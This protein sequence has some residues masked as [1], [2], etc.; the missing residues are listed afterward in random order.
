MR[1]LSLSYFYLSLSFLFF[2]SLSSLFSLSPIAQSLSSV[3]HLCQGE[4][5][6][7]LSRAALS[8]STSA[9][10]S[11][12]RLIFALQSCLR[13]TLLP[14]PSPSLLH[15]A[16]HSALSLLSFATGLQRS[17]LFFSLPP[18]LIT[19]SSS[20]F[21]LIPTNPLSPSFFLP[22][23]FYSLFSPLSFSTL[24]LI[25]FLSLFPFFSLSSFYLSSHLHLFF[26]IFLSFIFSLISPSFYLLSITYLSFFFSFFDLPIRATDYI[27]CQSLHAPS[28]L[29]I[30]FF[31]SFSPDLVLALSGFADGERA[32]RLPSL[33]GTSF[34]SYHHL[35][36]FYIQFYSSLFSISLTSF[37]ISI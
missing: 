11:L 29:A 37:F 22:F 19:F 21:F 20:S 16:L 33:A 31:F 8:G 27:H 23:L 17:C 12:S 34:S 28:Q 30:L 6:L 7:L 5:A 36:L 10:S 24:Y 35:F 25:T 4:S 1:C 9:R 14:P 18:L 3:S 32:L 15:L 26:I 2:I 13:F